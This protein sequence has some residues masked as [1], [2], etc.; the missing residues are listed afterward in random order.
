MNLNPSPIP[1][2]LCRTLNCLSQLVN[3]HLTVYDGAIWKD[4]TRGSHRTDLKSSAVH[5]AFS[6]EAALF[7]PVTPLYSKRLR[8]FR[9]HKASFLSLFCSCC[10]L[11][12]ICIVNIIPTMQFCRDIGNPPPHSDPQHPHIFPCI[13]TIV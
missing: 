2:S 11:L 7:S 5:R 8:C 1:L 12:C 10:F 4:A 6:W 13:I 3:L 9:N